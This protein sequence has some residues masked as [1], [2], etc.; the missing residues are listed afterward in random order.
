MGREQISPP[1]R[2][3][4]NQDLLNLEIILVNDF[5]TDSTLK[6]IESK[7]KNNK[8]QKKYGYIIFP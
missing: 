7:D 5:S 1:I 3:I 2:S 8:Q 4:Q 6:Y